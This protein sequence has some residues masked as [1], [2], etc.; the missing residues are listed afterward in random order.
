LLISAPET[1]PGKVVAVSDGDTIKVLQG[2]EQFKIRLNRIDA[3]EKNQSSGTKAKAALSEKIFGKD[4]RIE[5]QKKDRY[6]RILGDVY[7]GERWINK[8]MIAEGWAWHYKQFDKS[9]ELAQAETTARE[10]K[11]G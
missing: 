1:I 8:E 3:P 5:W 4:V 10:K 11:V 2:S 7:I 9:K 6:G